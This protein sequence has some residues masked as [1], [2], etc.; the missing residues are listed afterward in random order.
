TWQRRT[1]VLPHHP[2]QPVPNVL[3]W[4]AGGGGAVREGQHKTR[5]VQRFHPA[6]E[7]VHRHAGEAGGDL[8]PLGYAVDVALEGRAWQRLQLVEGPLAWVADQALDPET[9]IGRV[10]PR[11]RPGSEH[12]EAWFGV[13]TW[14]QPV[15]GAVGC[16]A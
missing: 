13:L 14:R 7:D 6:E 2:G 16:L 10:D 8:A 9:V 5:L 15:L 12:R 1:L 4:K 3:E 11:R